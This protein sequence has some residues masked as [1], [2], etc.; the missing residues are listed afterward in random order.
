MEV[1][2]YTSQ[3]LTLQFGKE[4]WSRR[5]RGLAILSVTGL[6]TF[7]SIRSGV[8]D[9]LTCDLA[10]TEGE[11]TL[12]AVTCTAT[13]H[14]W[15]QLIQRPR[16]LTDVTHAELTTER[17][18]QRRGSYTVYVIHLVSATDES[19]SFPGSLTARALQE[20]NVILLNQYLANPTPNPLIIQIDPN[21]IPW[22]QQVPIWGLL[23]VMALSGLFFVVIPVACACRFDR[24]L[25][26]FQITETSLGKTVTTTYPLVR[27]KRAQI[28]HYEDDGK[29]CCI[30]QVVLRP[31]ITL[32]LMTTYS[33]EQQEKA[34]TIINKFLNLPG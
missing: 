31:G 11:P 34:V 32:D 20:Q 30:T 3:K 27:V 29:T 16:T 9:R 8:A 13:R 23:L 15:S 14:H 18:R 22:W 24:R 28:K 2:E 10:P 25:E 19:Y 21:L 26:E 5:L 33:C 17:R 7:L 1:V 6:F 12:A 4:V